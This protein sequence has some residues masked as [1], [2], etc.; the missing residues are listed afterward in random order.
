MG[1]KKSSRT[2]QAQSGGQPETILVIRVNNFQ[3]ELIV[4][5][6]LKSLFRAI[7]KVLHMKFS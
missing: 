5:I 4:G 2:F 1:G 7:G 3:N 6:Y